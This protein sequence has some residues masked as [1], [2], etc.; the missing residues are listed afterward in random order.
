MIKAGIVGATGYAG[1]QLLWILKG[2]KDVDIEFISS[3]SFSGNNIGDIYTNYRK[4]FDKKLISMEEV[5]ENIKKIDVLFLALPHGMSEKLAKMALEEGK[6][7]IDLGADFRL[8]DSELYEKWYN[9]RHEFPEINKKAVYGLP[10]LYREKIAGSRI[11]ASPGCYPTSAILGTAPLLKNNI[12]DTG[13]IVIDSKSGVSGAGR[14]AKTDLIYTEVNEN[15]KAYNILKHRH[16]PEIK[17]EMEKLAFNRREGNGEYDINLIFAPHLLPI[18]R[19]ILSTIY[20]DVREGLKDEVTEEKL[21]R[22]YEDF[23]KGD[24][25]VRVSRDI[26][27]IKNVKNSNICEIGIRYDSKYGNIVIVSAIDNLI[28]GAG[29]QAVQSMNLMFGLPENEGLE[30]L[31]MYV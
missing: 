27:E 20:L 26:P 25:F 28:K 29:G 21:Y 12:I 15:F 16:T 6:A 23:Y 1:Q 9:V 19:G 18:N 4:Y 2:H 14:N 24:Y 10:E 3:N 30:F 17:Q 11:V 5:K 8:D 13:K 7:V 31:S 22:L